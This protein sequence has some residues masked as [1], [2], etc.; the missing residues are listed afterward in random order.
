ME[1]QSNVLLSGNVLVVDGIIEALG[2]SEPEPGVAASVDRIHTGGVIYP[3]LIDA[4]IIHITMRFYL[5]SWSWC[6][7]VDPNGWNNR[8]EWR[9]VMI[10]KMRLLRLRTD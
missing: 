7:R 10:T 2:M 4:I 6:T 1:S 5:G 9:T 8:Y 3:G